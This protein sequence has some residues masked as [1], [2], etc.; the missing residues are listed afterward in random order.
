MSFRRRAG[1]AAAMAVL[2]LAAYLP[3]RLHSY[4][5]VVYVVE[6]TLIQKAPLGSD[7]SV[8][9]ARLQKLL[10]AIPDRRARLAKAFEISQDMERVQTLTPGE[11]KQI[12]RDTTERP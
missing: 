11:L 4:S 9:R 3:A 2:A 8:L 10:D 12:L 5:L 7:P 6:Q 1:I